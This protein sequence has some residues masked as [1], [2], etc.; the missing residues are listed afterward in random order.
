MAAQVGNRTRRFLRRHQIGDEPF[1]ARDVFARNDCG[2]PD[3][4]VLRERRLDFAKLDP[5]PADLHLVIHSS[6]ILDVAAGQV[7]AEVSRLVKSRSGFVRKWIGDEL[8][9]RQL[10][11]PVVAASHLNAA[12]VQFTGDADRHGLEQA[13]QDEALRVCHRAADRHDVRFARP[14]AGPVGHIH[15]GFGGAVEIVKLARE[16]FEKGLLQVM[17]KRLS[18]ADDVTQARAV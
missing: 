2:F 3:G 9:G 14:L 17:R 11:A 8:L 15:R 18:A 12:D 5:E 1:V 4:F 7:A 13:I 16:S 6:E 10:R